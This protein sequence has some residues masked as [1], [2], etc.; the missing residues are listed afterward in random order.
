MKE[1][2]EKIILGSRKSQERASFLRSQEAIL[3]LTRRA[4][5]LLE[6]EVEIEEEEIKKKVRQLGD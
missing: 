2:V 6:H 3:K 4:Q 1:V 5:L